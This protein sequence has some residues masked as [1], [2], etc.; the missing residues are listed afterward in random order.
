VGWFM[1]RIA[2]LRNRRDARGGYEEPLESGIHG[3][4]TD[5][6]ADWDM[7]VGT[8]ADGTYAPGGYYEEQELGLVP[9]R[10][11]YE[12][13]GYGAGKAPKN[14][15]PHG[16]TERGRSRSR[17]SEVQS[18]LSRGDKTTKP[19]QDPFGDDAEGSNL[20]DVSPRPVVDTAGVSISSN[21]SAHEGNPAERASMFRESL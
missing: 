16:V 21:R 12:G 8:E 7:R 17:D 13:S 20:R 6:D 10:E 9:G 18:S 15:P 14:A 19:L 4:R 2:T 1:D 5:H 3:R 11:P